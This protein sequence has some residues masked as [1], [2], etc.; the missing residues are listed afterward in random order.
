VVLEGHQYH[1]LSHVL[2]MRPGQEVIVFDGGGLVG[3]ASISDITPTQ[4]VIAVDKL[5]RIDREKPKLHLYQAI[6]KMK[7]MD[8]V[9][10]NAVEMGIYSVVPVRC[11]RSISRCSS[12]ADRLQRW[13]K[14]AVESSRLAGRPYLPEIREPLDWDEALRSLCSMDKAIFADEESGE[15]TSLVLGDGLPEDVGMLVGPEGGFSDGER[16]ALTASGAIAVTLGNTIFRT[17]TAGMALSAAVRCH[18]GLL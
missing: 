7:K 9:I 15:R 8:T 13:R 3:R 18:Y 17:E 14:I 5:K 1:H 11:S 6:P 2:R 12:G 16:Q 10:Q 4:A